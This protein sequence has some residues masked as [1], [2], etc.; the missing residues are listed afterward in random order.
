VSTLH[1]APIAEIDPCNSL[2]P[3]LIAAKPVIVTE[4]I[5]EEV[6]GSA[7]GPNS[8]SNSTT[9][10]RNNSIASSSADGKSYRSGSL[11]ADRRQSLAFG[12]NKLASTP[13]S[14]SASSSSYFHSPDSLASSQV[15]GMRSGSIAGGASSSLPSPSSSSSSSAM[16][17]SPTHH[18]GSLSTPSAAATAFSSASVFTFKPAAPAATTHLL[19][20]PTF[21]NFTTDDS[22]DNSS[23]LSSSSSST[24]QPLSALPALQQSMMHVPCA[25]TDLRV[26]VLPQVCLHLVRETIF[27]YSAPQTLSFYL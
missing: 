21:G 3:L 4:T 17:F 2:L 27:P 15:G 22:A 1:L 6:A 9:N 18:R 5:V 25:A 14:A 26:V 8:R 13:T 11:A 20:S 19:P 16:V 7:S 24:K 10:S 12:A 23:S